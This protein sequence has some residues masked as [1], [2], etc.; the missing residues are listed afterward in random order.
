MNGYGLL[1]LG[2]ITNKYLCCFICDKHRSIRI[3]E[4]LLYFTSI[5]N[6][7]YSRYTCQFRNIAFKSKIN[8]DLD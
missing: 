2:L 8:I 5:D 7:L 4:F 1:L 6:S 3:K